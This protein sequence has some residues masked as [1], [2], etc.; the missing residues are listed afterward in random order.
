MTGGLKYAHNTVPIVTSHDVKL[1]A[2]DTGD[3]HSF[4]SAA[5]IEV[6]EHGHGKTKTTEAGRVYF[7]LQG[8]GTF[9]VKNCK[10][11]VQ[12]H[13]VIVIEKNTFYDFWADTGTKLKV[14]LVNIPAF[15]PLSEVS[16]EEDD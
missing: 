13:D 16:F 3:D 2:Y 5:L 11:S 15:N 14:L 4:A 6:G 9:N 12:P 10:E 7:V 1:W 8:S